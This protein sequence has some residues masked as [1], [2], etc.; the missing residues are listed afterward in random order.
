MPHL[1]FGTLLVVLSSSQSI[2][3]FRSNVKGTSVIEPLCA[4]KRVSALLTP[5]FKFGPPATKTQAL[6][7]FSSSWFLFYSIPS[8]SS[9][10]T[11]ESISA[12]ILSHSPLSIELNFSPFRYFCAILVLG[13]GF[14]ILPSFLPRSVYISHRATL[15]SISPCSPLSIDCDLSGFGCEFGFLGLGFLGPV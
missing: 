6:V 2:S 7:L 3:Q 9:S 8:R 14:L 10:Q 12:S 13:L 15:W 11:F 1:S 4:G 5:G